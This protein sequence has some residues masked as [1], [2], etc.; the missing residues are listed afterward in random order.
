VPVP[1][2]LDALA[3]GSAVKIRCRPQ[4]DADLPGAIN[5]DLVGF[6]PAATV[7]IRRGENAGE[8]I[9]YANIVTSWDRLGTWDGASDISFDADLADDGAYAVIVQAAGPGQVLAAI[10]LR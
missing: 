6:Q 9:S 4:A 7:D 5:I 8:T 10:R 3:D 2:E 1:I